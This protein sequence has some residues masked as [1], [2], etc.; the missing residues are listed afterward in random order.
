MTNN[1]AALSVVM[2][3]L[4]LGGMAS[5][6]QERLPCLTPKTVTMKVRTVRWVNSTLT[7]DTVL[8]TS[9]WGGITAT[10][11]KGYVYAGRS[12]YALTL[13]PISDTSVWLF[14]PDT[15]A[16]TLVDTITLRYDRVLTFL[17]NACG[18][19]YYFNLLSATNTK[20]S[21]DSIRIQDATITNNAN[22]NH[23]QIYVHPRL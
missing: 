5:C 7:T 1:T 22:T 17:S 6:T 9:V 13:S 3:L 23:I 21:I 15:T 11:V 14:A 19:T 8:E 2:L 20:N 10:G 4:F 12:S 18:Y 16:G